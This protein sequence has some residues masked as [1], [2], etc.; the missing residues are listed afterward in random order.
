MI[1]DIGNFFLQLE[2]WRGILLVISLVFLI[3]VFQWTKYY[4]LAKAD[5]KVTKYYNQARL[6]MSREYVIYGYESFAEKEY[7][8]K[9]IVKSRELEDELGAK[10]FDYTNF[11]NKYNKEIKIINEQGYL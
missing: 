6:D 2:W 7:I 10:P 11:E 4:W 8:D 1:N 3:D 9:A 5:M